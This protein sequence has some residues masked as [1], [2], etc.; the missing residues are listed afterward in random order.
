[1][2][3]DGFVRTGHLGAQL[4]VRK[5]TDGI[6]T[7]STVLED[8]DGSVLGVHAEADGA[9]SL[10]VSDPTGHVDRVMLLQDIADKLSILIKHAEKINLEVYTTDDPV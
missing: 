1:M 9:K 6:V 10:R 2:A 5:A 7:P 4:R 8:G 3:T